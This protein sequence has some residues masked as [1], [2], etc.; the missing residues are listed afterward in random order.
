[1]NRNFDTFRNNLGFL[2]I[3]YYY[4]LP[5]VTKKKS[6]DL[7]AINRAEKLNICE[8]IENFGK[9]MEGVTL[10]KPVAVGF[11][12]TLVSKNILKILAFWTI[13]IITL[14]LRGSHLSSLSLNG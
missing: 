3:E 9:P 13:C 6:I 2:I 8:K 4:C 5:A 7:T 12:M 10:L 11:R 1:M 14:I